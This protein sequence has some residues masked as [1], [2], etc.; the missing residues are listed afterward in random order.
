MTQALDPVTR[1]HIDQAAAR[2]RDQFTGFGVAMTEGF[3]KP[4]TDE[5]VRAAPESS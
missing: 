5:V 1:Q 3:P 2:L 4:L